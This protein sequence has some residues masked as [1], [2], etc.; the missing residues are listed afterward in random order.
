MKK[1]EKQFFNNIT[2]KL[3]IVV[4]LNNNHT[5][6]IILCDMKMIQIAIIRYKK[7]KDIK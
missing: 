7:I 5:N 3:F 1:D 2:I 6:K 4:V